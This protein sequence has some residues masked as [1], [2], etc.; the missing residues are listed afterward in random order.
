MTARL[1]IRHS[2]CAHVFVSPLRLLRVVSIALMFFGLVTSGWARDVYS[3][4]G[5]V[6]VAPSDGGRQQ[7]ETALVTDSAGRVWLSFIDAEYKQ[8]ANSNWIAWPR[9]CVPKT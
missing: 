2:R 6:A 1:A 7:G 3:W 9:L 4:S 8:I 5:N